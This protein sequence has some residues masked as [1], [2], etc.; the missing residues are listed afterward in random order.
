MDGVKEEGCGRHGVIGDTITSIAYGPGGEGKGK[1][2]KGG[3]KHW[4]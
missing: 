1:V 2:L 3:P 4:A